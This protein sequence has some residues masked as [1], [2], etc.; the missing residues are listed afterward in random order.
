MPHCTA[1]TSLCRRYGHPEF[2]F[3]YDSAA[4]IGP[5]V[6]SFLE[7]LV[8]QVAAGEVYRAGETFQIGWMITRLMEHKDGALGFL[9]P[10]ML[11]FPI[12]RIEGLTS[13]LCH[14]RLH[15]DVCE[16]LFDPAQIVFAPLWHSAVVCTRLGSAGTFVMDRFEPENNSTG[17]F[18]GCDGA[19]HDH[20]DVRHL[21]R[22]SVY[23]AVVCLERR[24]LPYILL[25]PGTFL[26]GGDAPLQ[27]W[28]N[29]ESRPFLAGSYLSSLFLAH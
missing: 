4:V 7:S 2:R 18:F 25:P 23:E 14:L 27:V 16:S 8:A 20:Q 21:R 15:K 19:E 1:S 9:E 10:D 6:N 22:V 13:S 26:L 5:T 11:T 12:S 3:T 28:H 17:W 24:V 29:D